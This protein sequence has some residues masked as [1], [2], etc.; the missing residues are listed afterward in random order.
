MRQTEGGGEEEEEE[1]DEEG[2]GRKGE[3]K[4]REKGKEQ[5]REG[6]REKKKNFNFILSNFFIS[7]RK[8][9]GQQDGSTGNG[10]CSQASLRKFSPKAPYGRQREHT[11]AC[12]SP[13]ATL[14]ALS[15]R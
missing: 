9:K 7:K 11:P 8:L 5:W 4:E 3:R 10:T 13:T 12:C 1:E 6:G 2:M 14:C 15:I